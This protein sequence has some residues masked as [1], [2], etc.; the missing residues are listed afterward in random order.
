MD[1][2]ANAID[3]QGRQEQTELLPGLAGGGG[4]W[5]RSRQMGETQRGG[6]RKVRSE[7]NSRSQ[8][9]ETCWWVT[10]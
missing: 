8:G 10:M 4:D 3:I 5:V 6:E 9:Q 1:Q 7:G 2:R